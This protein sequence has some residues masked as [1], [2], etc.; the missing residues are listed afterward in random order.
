[1]RSGAS[2]FMGSVVILDSDF[3]RPLR[4]PLE[5]DAPLVADADGVFVFS[6]A[7]E[8]VQ[9]VGW[10]KAE[11]F[12]GRGSGEFAELPQGSILNLRRQLARPL[13]IPDFLG[14]LVREALNHD[15]IWRYF[16]FPSIGKFQGL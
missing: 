8:R 15:K 6:V 3:L 1:M 13:A 11:C 14:F 16:R 9:A 2:V 12:K 7:Q 10:R 5:G 4:S